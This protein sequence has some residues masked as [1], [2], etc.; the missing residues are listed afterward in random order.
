MFDE[1]YMTRALELAERGQGHVEPNPMVGCVVVRD[2]E[3]VGEGFHQQFGG[4]HAEVEALRVAGRRANGATL[5]VT[6]EPCCHQGKTPP[7][8]EA[9]VAAGIRRVVAPLADPFEQ[10]AGQGF[11]QLRSAGVS[12]EIGL[13]EAPARR[14]LAP[15]LK[16]VE[17]GIPWIIAKWA[18]TLDGKIAT[19]S[20][21]SRWISG[22]AAR[23]IVHRLRGRVDAILVGRGTVEADDP[24]LTARPPGPRIATRVVLDSLAAM[25]LASQL[26]RTAGQAPVLVA[27]SSEAPVERCDA[28]R[29]AGCEVCT[30]EGNSTERVVKLLK[31]LAKRGMTNVLVE[32]GGRVLGSLL[33]AGQIDEVHVFVAPKLVGGEAAATPIGG[34]GIGD[35]SQALQLD[36]PRI[37][38]LGTDVY[39]SGRVRRNQP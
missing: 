15:F 13:L 12:V 29:A 27:A 16:R 5:Y 28:L 9:I 7:C 37:E 11:A 35:L 33:E 10:V 14:L 25:P 32:G 21:Q 30:F 39:V 26:V 31:E 22:H 17:Q 1:W 3:V 4:A 2:G 6:L 18:M 23:E 20:G 34:Q 38:Q 24:L 19:R 36:E 8:S